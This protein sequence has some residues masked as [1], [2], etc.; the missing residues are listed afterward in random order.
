MGNLEYL[1]PSLQSRQKRRD[2]RLGE[3]LIECYRYS[4]N[5]RQKGSY[6]NKM[7]AKNYSQAKKQESMKFMHAGG[8]KFFNDNLEPLIRFLNTHQGKNWNKV[9]KELCG[10]LDKR[11]VSG[12]H[13]FNH[14][15]DFVMINVRIENGSVFTMRFGKWEE[16]F[17]REKWPKFYINSKTGQLRKAKFFKKKQV[18]CQSLN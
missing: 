14:L 13:V 10:K 3:E 12:L 7:R 6:K 5:E 15:W 9:Y 17:S 4:I 18:V 8:T 16:L 11:S 2:K 1:K